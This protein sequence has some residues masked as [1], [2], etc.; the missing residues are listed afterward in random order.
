MLT[1]PLKGMKV[2]QNSLEFGRAL[3]DMR[4]S[5]GMSQLKLAARLGTT[6]RHISF[7]E[8]GRSKATKAFLQRLCAD[9]D[10]S[11][12]QRSA[13]FDASDYRNP[14]ADR[15]MSSA[16][17]EAALQNIETRILCNWPFPA[18]ALDQYWN[19]LRANASSRAMFAKFGVSLD[20][21][22]VNLVDVV[23][24]DAFR[25]AVANWEHASL[26]MYFRLQRAAADNDELAQKFEAIKASG[27]FDHVPRMLTGGPALPPLTPI[28]FQIPDGPTLTVSPFVGKLASIQ[29]VTLEGVEIELMVP[30]D[31][32]SDAMLRSFAD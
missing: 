16:E 26:G 24:T 2:M 17:I 21:A 10:L 8:T 32:A 6:Q 15:G 3:Q 29:D 31:H 13:L 11:A 19:V 25:A 23:L 12:A 5:L 22:P 1:I 18:F 7:L 28:I 30:L 14:F 4:K 27:V 9:L 20:E